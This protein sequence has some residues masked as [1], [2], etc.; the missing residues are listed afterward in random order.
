[1]GI[2]FLLILLI[3]PYIVIQRLIAGPMATWQ[4]SSPLNNQDPN[5]NII[6]VSIL[7]SFHAMYLLISILNLLLCGFRRLPIALHCFFCCL[8]DQ[9]CSM[10]PY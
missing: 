10:D 8:L 7:L 9:Y 1:M 6:G 3:H 2:S 4:P 5:V